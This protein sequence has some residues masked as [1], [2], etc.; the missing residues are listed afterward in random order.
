MLEFDYSILQCPVSGENLLPVGKNRREEFI[1]HF[2]SHP[3]KIK[4]GFLNE[5][6]T[7]LYPMVEDIILLL[8]VYALKI[9]GKPEE[10][11]MSFDRKRVFEYYNRIHYDLKNNLSIYEDSPKW[12]DFRDV[13]QDYLRHSFARAGKYLDPGGEYFLDVGSGPIGLEEYIELSSNYTYRICVDISVNALIRAKANY[14]PR[15]GIYIC[16]DITNI[17]VKESVCDAVLCQH[18]LY[19]VPKNEQKN[20][21]EEMHRVLKPG[22]RMA[23][24]YSLFYHSW[25]MNISLFPVQVYRI[26]RHFTGKVYARIFRKR[27]RLYF[28]AHSLRWF[29]RNFGQVYDMGFYSWRSTNKYFLKIYIHRHLWGARLLGFL[30]ILEDRFPRFLGT[31][32]EYPLIVIRKRP[33]GT[34]NTA[35]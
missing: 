31:F 12:V 4:E 16:G 27:P 1:R 14:S 26:A 25:F 33:A 2:S 8:P 29:R 15:K 22:K 24:V 30:K 6:G 10:D 9:K 19:H 32:G 3:M 23:V 17:P 13:T 28:Y 20:A 5:S 7:L 35:V 21:V 18:T 34:G 11:D